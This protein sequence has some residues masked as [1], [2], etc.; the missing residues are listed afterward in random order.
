[1]FEHLHLFKSIFKNAGNNVSRNLDFKV[2]LGN[3]TPLAAHAYGPQ[4][5]PN[6]PQLYSINET[7]NLKATRLALPVSSRR[8]LCRDQNILKWKVGTRVELPRETSSF[9]PEKYHTVIENL[10][11]DTLLKWNLI[12]L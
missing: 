12:K 7:F 5:P 1:M 10:A 11:V 6:L 8:E 2:F 9:S 4:N 3:Q